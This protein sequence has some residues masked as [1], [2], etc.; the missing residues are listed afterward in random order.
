[1][2]DPARWLVFHGKNDLSATLS[3]LESSAIGVGRLVQW[4][5]DVDKAFELSCVEQLRRIVC[6]RRACELSGTRATL[7]GSPLRQRCGQASRRDLV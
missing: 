1:M 6:H 2:S 7:L 3:L 5:H 4:D